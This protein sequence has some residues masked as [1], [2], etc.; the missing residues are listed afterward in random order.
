MLCN[1][2]ATTRTVF[3]IGSGHDVILDHDRTAGNIDTIQLADGITTDDVSVYRDGEDLVLSLNGGADTLTVRQWFWNDSPEYRVEVIQ[4]ADGTTWDVDTVKQMV[5]QPTDGDDTLIGTSVSDALN[6][7]GGNDRIFG[8]ADDD[9]LDGGTGNDTVAGEAGNDTLL[10]GEGTDTLS[11]GAGNDILDGGIGNDALYGGTDHDWYGYRGSN[12]SDTYRF[13][14]GSGQDTVVDYDDTAG[15]L[16]TI[17]LNAD[18]APADVSI[19]RV[20]HNLVLS[21]IDTDDTLTVN[22]WF[23]DESGTWQVEQ[24]QFGDGTLWNAGDIKQMVLQ[25]TPEDDLLIGY[26]TDDTISGI[27]GNDAIYGNAGN[28]TLDGGTGDDYLDGGI[29]NDIYRFDRGSG[30]DTVVDHDDTAGNI[31]T[32]GLAADVMPSDVTLEIDGTNLRIVINNTDNTLLVTGWFADDASKVERIEFADGTVWDTQYIQDNARSENVILGTPGN[33]IL[34]GT[35]RDD[36]LIGLQGDDT[37]TGGEGN[38]TYVFTKGSGVDR[39]IENDSTTGNLDVVKFLDV[40]STELD[41]MER[42]GNDL[43]LFYGDDRLTVVNYY[44]VRRRADRGDT[45][46]RRNRP[47]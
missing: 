28:D 25:G 4:F 44:G 8:R 1:P 19:R 42:W 18:V 10:G 26:S 39:I 14:R 11:G 22:D 40:T 27:A 33:D 38:D 35:D 45:I 7:Y 34:V 30:Q 5:L 32:I 46:Q 2:T 37:L 29:G 6:G 23:T 31:D 15:N 21:I 20:D 9:T 3:G 12:G 17:L 24:I 13:A 47:G 43:V 41:G 36:T 16:D